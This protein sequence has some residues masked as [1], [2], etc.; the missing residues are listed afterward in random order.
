MLSPLFY[1]QAILLA[2]GQIWANKT[3]AFLTALGIIIGVGSVTAVIAAL[4][5]LKGMVLTEFET[6][7]A[8]KM[9]IFPQRPDNSPRNL[10]PWQDIRLKP[11]ELHAI[12]EHCPS[13]RRLT[14]ITNF[15]TTVQH[16]HTRLDGISVTGIWPTWHDIERRSVLIGRPFTQIDEDNARQVCLVNDKAIQELK[17]DNDPTGT[18]LLLGGRRYLI[19]GVVETL[20]PSIF[21][22]ETTHTEV[23]IPFSTA[24]RLQPTWFFFHI[25]AQVV[26]PEAAE[27]AKSEV[28][29]VLRK[30]RNLKGDQPDTFRAEAIDQFINQFKAIA[31]GITAIA[32]GIVGI[33]LLVGGIGIMNIM[34]VSVSE[35]TR[36]IGLRKA[37]GATP[38]AILTQFL[39]EAV[40]LSFVG[41][42]IGVAL[43]QLLA[44]S[45]TQIP[46]A[47]LEH[48]AVPW[49]AIVMAF[50]FS[51]AVGVIFG[52]FPA[53]KAARLDPIEA[54]RHE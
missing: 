23:F 51:A 39:L 27:E 40:T 21:G 11:R 38:A 22:F 35:R 17:L 25:I 34:L 18:H 44:L 19:V 16:R 45:M 36:E 15:G 52:M 14:P 7:G 3:R 50:G 24:E 13:I 20:Q 28:N 2:L 46:G 26:A 30:M 53:I 33:S 37:V 4:T 41:G 1:I 6:I 54:L 47:K 49:W 48:A 8:S 31:A 43:G 9:F 5:G 12:A 10:Y 32:G 42:L 29:F